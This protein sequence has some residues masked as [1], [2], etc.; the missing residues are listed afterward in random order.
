MKGE[1]E[2][3]LKLIFKLQMIMLIGQRSE[4]MER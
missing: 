4:V 3:Q 1:V 2:I